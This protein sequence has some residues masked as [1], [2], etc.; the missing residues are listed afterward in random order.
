[1]KKIILTIPFFLI[2]SC[3]FTNQKVAMNFDLQNQ[4]STI[5]NNRSID[6]Q[7]IDTR[8]SKIL[9]KKRISEEK[10]VEIEL[11]GD[12][13][14]ELK[15]AVLQNLQGRGFKQGKDK[16]IILNIEKF[17]YNAKIGYPVGT[18]KSE[19]DIKVTVKDNRNGVKFVK[20][21]GTSLSGKHFLFPTESTVSENVNQLLHDVMQDIISDDNFMDSLLR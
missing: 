6:V 2:I 16:E 11:D 10:A 15:D 19:L 21:Y 5:G 20:N 9:G 17:S 13:S 18:S 12:L 8:H 14:A 3:A 7:I 1:M 4:S